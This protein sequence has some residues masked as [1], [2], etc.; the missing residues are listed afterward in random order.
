M[1]R[2]LIRMYAEAKAQLGRTDETVKA[3]NV[4]R[5]VAGGLP[6]YNE[7][8]DQESLVREMLHQ[9]RHAPPQLRTVFR[10]L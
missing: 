7:P 9:R 4:I 10:V 3:L 6:A 1:K 5:T 2:E 8:T